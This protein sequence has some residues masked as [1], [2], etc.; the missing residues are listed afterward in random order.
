MD[1]ALCVASR[2]KLSARKYRSVSFFRRNQITCVLSSC[3]AVCIQEFVKQAETLLRDK[4]LR[5][6]IIANAREYIETNHSE[7]VE[8]RA[9]S[10]VATELC[11]IPRIN[12]KELAIDVM[13]DFDD[14]KH[15]VRFQFNSDAKPAT[16][17]SSDRAENLATATM[18]NSGFQGKTKVAQKPTVAQLA[19]ENEDV[20]SAENEK[21]NRVVVGES[22]PAEC[23][24]DAETR[25]QISGFRS[26]VDESSS[27]PSDRAFPDCQMSKSLLASAAGEDDEQLV[28]TENNLPCVMGGLKLWINPA[29]ATAPSTRS[30]RVAAIKAND[31]RGATEPSLRRT[32]TKDGVQTAAPGKVGGTIEKNGLAAT[33]LSNGAKKPTAKRTRPS[34]TGVADKTKTK[35]ADAIRRTVSDA[36]PRAMFEAGSK[37]YPRSQKTKK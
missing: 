4:K 12:I 24:V 22:L 6:T 35:P 37:P 15:R 32:T 17:P 31:R 1:T 13:D 19:V 21:Q 9:Y 27:V 30:P 26:D 16:D 20:Q 11:N 7:E 18:S 29:T 14:Y 8:Y 10:K 28:M 34:C 5:N 2:G 33:T 36:T 23:S 25:E 3:S